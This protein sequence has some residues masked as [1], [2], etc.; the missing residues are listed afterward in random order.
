MNVK[1][2]EFFR[3][4]MGCGICMLVSLLLSVYWNDRRWLGI[5]AVGHGVIMI[6]FCAFILSMLGESTLAR[7]H[8]VAALVIFWTVVCGGLLVPGALLYLLFR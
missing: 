2:K 6:S 4:A 5:A 8:A 1:C 3:V 7:P